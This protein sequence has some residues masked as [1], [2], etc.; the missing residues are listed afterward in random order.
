MTVSNLNGLLPLKKEQLK[1]ASVVC[2]RAFMDDPWTSYIIPD[3]KKRKITIHY[4]LESYLRL[5]LMV[6]EIYTV[7][8]KIEGVAGWM[9]S[10]RKIG[11][12]T[13]LRSRFY[14][15]AVKSGFRAFIR[16]GKIDDFYDKIKKKRAP[17]KHRYLALLAVDPKF[18]GKG[19]RGALLKPM[20]KRL[21]KE[22]M[23][24]WVD[25]SREKNISFYSHF[26]FRVMHQ[27]EYRGSGL[28]IT[29][30][31]RDPG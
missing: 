7:S 12:I 17:K 10:D 15:Y 29:A 22:K 31:Q 9:L 5:E 26:G 6:G 13:L 11:L 28:V 30:M 20:L 14:I 2:S 8:P 21:D 16:D 18:Q 23:P 1:E 24:C 27:E 25:T 4:M 19:Y 3:E